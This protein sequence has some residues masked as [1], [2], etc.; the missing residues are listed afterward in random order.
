MT[1]LLRIFVFLFILASIS[2][3]RGLASE[4]IIVSTIQPRPTIDASNPENLGEAVFTA[5]CASCHGDTGLGDGA[6]A[7]EA[8]LNPPN[9]TLASTSAEQSLA[10]WINTIRFGRLENMMPPWENS[11]SEEEIEAVAEYT[12]TLWQGFPQTSEATAEPPAPFVE[13]AIGTVTGEII[14]CTAGASTPDIISVALHVINAEGNEADFEMQV[15]QDGASYNFENILIRH[16]YT[17]VITAIHNEVLFYSEVQYGTPETPTMTL[18]ISIYEVTHDESVIEIDLFLLRLIPD[19]DELVVQ[20]IINFVNTSDYVYRGDNQIDGFTYDSV[21]IPIPNEAEVLNSVE[22]V[23]RFLMLEGEGQQTLLDTQPVLPNTDH[24]VEVVYTL[25]FSITDSRLHIELPTY[26][27]VIQAAEVM[28]QSGQFIVE[29]DDFTSSGIQHFSVGVY[30]SYLSESLSANDLIQFDVL[31]DIGDI[32]QDQTTANRRNL[33]ALLALGGIAL[34][35]ISSI[36]L[37]RGK[38]AESEIDK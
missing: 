14:Q 11:L 26:Y 5:R 31:P 21:R 36:I 27:D 10:Q 28:V 33:V 7:L 8:G 2:A 4:P 23:P 30:E 20:Q 15:L 9:F 38:N 34:L 37:F 19:G 16:D 22:L 32:D 13:E 1:T 25:P 12:Y 29:S 35:S 6:V 18:P 3:C 17:Y 24:L